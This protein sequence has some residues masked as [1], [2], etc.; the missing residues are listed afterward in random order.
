MPNW[1]FRVKFRLPDG[2]VLNEQSVEREIAL[3]EPGPYTIRSLG[4]KHPIKAIGLFSRGRPCPTR[5]RLR[6]SVNGPRTLCCG[7]VRAS[8]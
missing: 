8:R 3:A 6:A 1:T 5:D 2:T 4:R 7:A